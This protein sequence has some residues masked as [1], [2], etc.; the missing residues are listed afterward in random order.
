MFGGVSL[1]HL[2]RLCLLSVYSFT[3]LRDAYGFGLDDTPCLF[4]NDLN[5]HRIT[6]ALG[7]ALVHQVGVVS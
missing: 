6:W 3:L 2:P 5:G 1:D 4:V 7:A